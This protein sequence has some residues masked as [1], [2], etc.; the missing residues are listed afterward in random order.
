MTHPRSQLLARK[1]DLLNALRRLEVDRSAGTVDQEAYV[2]TRRRY[3]AE[4]ATVLQRLDGLRG[5]D[6]EASPGALPSQGRPGW[7]VPSAVA[8]AV[9]VAIIVLLVE[10]VRPRVDVGT[11]TGNAPPAVVAPT[12][13]VPPRLI[14]AQRQARL[15]PASL[16]ALLNLGTAYMN[17]GDSRDADVTF[18]RA[19][20]LAPGRPEAATM[21]ALLLGSAL[22]RPSQALTLLLKVEGA[23]PGYARA[24]LVD[25]LIS[26]QK[27]SLLPRAIAA[28]QRFLALDP[29]S[30]VAP[31]VRKILA[32]LHQ[33]AKR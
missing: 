20:K 16:Q 7:V 33:L 25:G 30:Q 1:D 26:A 10:A 5:D 9:L 23:H 8:A 3:E 21:H 4:A 24:W 18:Q 29:R 27:R 17:A 22:N 11:I 15:H 31:G 32:R 12:A 2:S 19:M 6:K 28:Y 13:S 14:A